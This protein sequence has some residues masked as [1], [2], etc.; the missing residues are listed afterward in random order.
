MNNPVIENSILKAAEQKIEASLTPEN[1]ANYMKI[2]VGGMK[3]AL[4][5]G[6]KGI[7]AS[8]QHSKDPLGD[9]AKGAV[10]LCGIMAKQSRG[11]M[12][13]M[14]MVPAATTLMLHALDFL[15]KIGI[16]K[17]GAPELVKAT[18][19]MAEAIFKNVG[20]D[21]K[22]LQTA[23]AKVHGITQDPAQLAKLKQQQGGAG[24]GTH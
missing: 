4:Q 6:P 8:L 19:M 12:P 14:A 13:L 16:M 5:G 20:I 1:R 9:S 22:M 17:I 11:T 2:V 24:A 18:K 15:D 23:A 10:N 7:L 3:V 21:K